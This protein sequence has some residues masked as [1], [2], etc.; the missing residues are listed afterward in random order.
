LLIKLAYAFDESLSRRLGNIH[1]PT[2]FIVWSLLG[3]T[4]GGISYRRNSK[5]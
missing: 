2:T 3:L 4:A 5:A 1:E